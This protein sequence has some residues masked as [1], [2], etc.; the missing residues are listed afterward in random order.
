VQQQNQ[1]GLGLKVPPL[2]L[3]ALVAA[4]MWVASSV[5]PSL[6][7]VLPAAGL[8]SMSLALLGAAT[9]LSGVISFRRAKTTVNPMK[10]DSASSLVVS[11]IYRYTRNP[12]YL[13]FFLIL[14]GWAAFLS[15]LLAV[16]LAFAFVAYMNR[17]QIGAEERAL[18]ALFPREYSEYR[19]RV[20][21]WV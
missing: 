17:F 20:R 10:P 13:G 19:A 2:G 9:C 3:V 15:N 6:D 5:S 11:G 14:L 18:G 16:A 21:R 7:V 12:M 1:N 4:L 8:S